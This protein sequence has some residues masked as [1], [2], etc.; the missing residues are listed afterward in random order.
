[1]DCFRFES[2]AELRFEKFEPVGA[3]A[4]L[5]LALPDDNG[6][7]SEAFE[8]PDVFRV[9]LLVAADFF[10]PEVRICLRDGGVAAERVAVPE[11]A[12]DEN[13]GVIFPQ[14]D[15]RTARQVFPVQGIAK[16]PCMQESARNHLRTRVHAPNP[17]H[18]IMPLLFCH[19]VR[20]S[21][22]LRQR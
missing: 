12:V 18:A 14:H 21:L 9:A 19:L 1:M 8:F 4:G 3:A 2:L 7:P 11:A 6:V 13:D 16:P 22:A 5:E 17:R 20:H 10:L 15:V